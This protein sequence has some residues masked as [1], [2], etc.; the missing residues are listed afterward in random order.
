M[1]PT[2]RATLMPVTHGEELDY[3][4]KTY[5]LSRTRSDAGPAPYGL[6][7]YWVPVYGKDSDE[8]PSLLLWFLDSRSS[9]STGEGQLP[10]G[11]LYRYVD[12]ETIPG[13]IKSQGDL[14]KQTVRIAYHSCL[15][16]HDQW[17]QVP[18]SLF[19]SHIPVS[20][21]VLF[22]DDFS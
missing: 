12:D 7:N 3:E 19:F 8:E 20:V 4:Q 18:P 22:V 10:D 2:C 15:F 1:A 6:A 21:S 14:M 16:A 11:A 17:K 13:Y 9:V 5:S